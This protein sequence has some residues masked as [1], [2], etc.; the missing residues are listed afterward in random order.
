LLGIYLR[1][2][3]RLVSYDNTN[4]TSF[5]ELLKIILV[6]L[7]QFEHLGI[8]LN[9]LALLLGCVFLLNFLALLP[10]FILAFA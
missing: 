1:G 5:F 6:F 4:N 3:I 10:F 9:L 2:G 8:L 7:Q